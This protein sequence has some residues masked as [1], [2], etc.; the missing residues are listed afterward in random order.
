MR[1]SWDAENDELASLVGEVA[2]EF[3]DRFN[4]GEP[5][6]IEEYAQRHPQITEILRQVLPSLGLVRQV[7]S[8][9][10]HGGTRRGSLTSAIPE[11][12]GEY[13]IVREVGRGGM[14]VVYEADQKS[15]GRR[16]ALK[17]LPFHRLMDQV[18]LKRFEREAQAA[19]RL[20]HTNIVPVFGAGEHEGVHFYAMQY[21]A[22][23]GL[24]RVI[25]ELRRRRQLTAGSG[26]QSPEMTGTTRSIEPASRLDPVDGN[27]AC[28]SRDRNPEGS[29]PTSGSVYDGGDQD[30]IV[31]RLYDQPFLQYVRSVAGLGVQVAQAL[32]YAHGQGIVHRDIKPSN[33]MLDPVATVWVTDFGLAK[34][35]NSEDL[36]HSGDVIGTLRY[37][38]P[39]GLTGHF[40]ARSDIFGLGLTLY[41]LLT[42]RPGYDAESRGALLQQVAAAEPPP[43]RKIDGRIPPDLN[44]IVEKAIA[45]EPDRRYATAALL[46]DDLQRFLDD[47]PVAARRTGPVGHA[48]RWCRR[49]PAFAGLSSGT[50]AV[51]LVGSSVIFWQ[52]RL[53]D[54]QRRI[55]EANFTKARD[56]VDDCF[57]KVTG[58]PAFQEP[59]M[60]AA[61][62]VLLKA[63]LKYYRDFSN[64]RFDDPSI[65]ADLGRAYY[66]LGY[67][68]QRIASK[69]EALAAYEQSRSLFELLVESR[70]GDLQPRSELANCDEAIG[71]LH[72]DIGRWDL[73]ERELLKAQTL[74]ESLV[75]ADPTTP[76][77]R[78][79]LANAL[80]ML[81]T[82]HRLTSRPAQ[83]EEYYRRG[84]EHREQIVREYPAHA[85][86]RNALARDYSEL[87]RLFA[88][89][90]RPG[91]AESTLTKAVATLEQ[92][93]HDDPRSADYRDSLAT[94]YN[95]LGSLL[96][97]SS[98]PPEAIESAYNKALALREQLARDHP[99]VNEYRSELARVHNNLALCHYVAQHFE[100]AAVHYDKALAL[101]VELWREHPLELSYQKA[102]AKTHHDLGLL[103]RRQGRWPEADR[104]FREALSVMEPLAERHPEVS[105]FAV[106]LASAS[107][108]LGFLS[109]DRAMHQDSVDWHTRAIRG[110]NAVLQSEPQHTEARRL[111]AQAYSGR[112]RS[113]TYLSKYG[114]ALADWNRSLEYAIENVVPATR[115]GRATT[116]AYQGRYLEA[117]AEADRI[118]SPVE[119][120][121][122]AQSDRARVYAVAA[123]ACAADPSVVGDEKLDRTDR[124]AHRAM[125]L[126]TRGYELGEFPSKA[127]VAT[128]KDDRDFQMLRSRPDFVAWLQMVEAEGKK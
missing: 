51:L 7:V 105:D 73:A 115:I 56:A 86:F 23:R 68:T 49:N 95:F 91:Q 119:G 40:D 90:S 106:E 82:L 97:N 12:L 53:T 113:L 99:R 35:E 3:T 75:Q 78:N 2:D 104:S 26:K 72:Q 69:T 111:L 19:A 127:S 41:E 48:W 21:I 85:D 114:E 8:L 101:R 30:E 77:R 65:R 24:D 76:D 107:N 109:R 116:L 28:D 9:S 117:V 36:T 66:R 37:A 42:L 120:K 102:V 112:A 79:D 80:R 11:Y 94:A 126:L 5:V 123:G 74:R 39:E 118:T 121:L 10:S 108:N 34:A 27:H 88:A 110:S 14:G 33:L 45:R 29:A 38:A 98:R 31:A 81:G 58:D 103:F 125:E 61:R 62:Q 55:A 122:P 128:L 4:R 25:R 44:T 63:A 15:L 6:S 50:L 60:E 17:V 32:A 52:W 47:R 20:H 93:V 83:A 84:Q 59:G 43:P 96:L 1:E 64:Q 71:V 100:E 46:A 92:L 22:G 18:Y 54:H 87:A 57:S 70:P 16:V 89:T 67:I 124:F 13:R